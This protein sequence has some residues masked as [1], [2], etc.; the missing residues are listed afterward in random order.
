MSLRWWLG[1]GLYE[2]HGVCLE[3]ARGHVFDAESNLEQVRCGQTGIIAKG[4]GPEDLAAIKSLTDDPSLYESCS[5][6]AL[7][8]ARSEVGW[9]RIATEIA[10]IAKE[11]AL[12]PRRRG[13]R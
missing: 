9:S 1:R 5:A 6:G 8:H 7:E 13:Q 10:A 2:K 3:R 12:R 4:M 11:A